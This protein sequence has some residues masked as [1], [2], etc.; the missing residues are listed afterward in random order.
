MRLI[1]AQRLA[2]GKIEH[3][4]F[5]SLEEFVEHRRTGEWSAFKEL[6]EIVDELIEAEYELRDRMNAPD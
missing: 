2:R 5:T 1:H 6:D 4:I 3:R